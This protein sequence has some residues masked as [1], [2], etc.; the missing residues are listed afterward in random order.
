M[1]LSRKFWNFSEACIYPQLPLH[2]HPMMFPQAS[3][4]LGRPPGH[5][6]VGSGHVKSHAFFEGVASS[7]LM[8]ILDE[9]PTARKV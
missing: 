1:A 8:E 4:T 5:S 3:R 2:S 7:V 6:E 9:T